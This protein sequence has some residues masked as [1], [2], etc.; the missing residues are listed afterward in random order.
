[1]NAQTILN[2]IR[3]TFFT[4]STKYE[5]YSAAVQREMF[6]APVFGKKRIMWNARRQVVETY[7]TTIS[8]DHDIQY[9]TLDEIANLV[10]NQKFASKGYSSYYNKTA[11]RVC[12]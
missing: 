10:N 7:V 5:T 11:K 4:A 8:R 2:N 3:Y 1:M 9:Y 6:G 12:K